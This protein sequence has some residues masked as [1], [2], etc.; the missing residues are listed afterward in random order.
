MAMRFE[1]RHL[2]AFVLL[3]EELHFRRAA[4][5]LCMTQPALSRT[6]RSLEEDIGVE[7]L[8]RTT[9]SVELTEAG[10]VFLAECREVLRLLERGVMRTHS[11]ALGDAGNV[12]VAYTD[13][14]I[15]GPLPRI[16][17]TFRRDHPG[18]R[19]EL[20]YIPTV[21]QKEEILAGHI[22]VGLLIGPFQ[23]KG[24]NSISVMRDPLV[25]LLPD[26]HPLT[27]REAITLKDLADEPFV[28]G[29]KD[30]WAA[31]RHV[32]F[33]ACRE[34]GFSPNVVQEASTSDGIFGLVSANIGVSL[35][36]SCVRSIQRQG[37]TIRSLEGVEHPVETLAVWRSDS[38]SPSVQR[39][40]DTLSDT[41]G[42]PR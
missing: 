33:E 32:V 10:R 6:I 12:A 4:E 35:Y 22:D 34:A 20:S 3:A 16:L 41:I 37:L 14:A 18:I 1:L 9:R 30:S 26:G 31:Y 29:S 28:L 13:F 36:P 39:F 8:L 2:R 7:L 23:S 11:A 25:A 5:R 17:E 19:V 40:V 38:V 42:H 21:F 15:N 24:V 27:R